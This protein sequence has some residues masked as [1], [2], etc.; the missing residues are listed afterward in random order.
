MNS[1]KGPRS[2]LADVLADIKNSRTEDEY[3]YNSHDLAPTP[4]KRRAAV[5]YVA[6]SGHTP[7][8]S[9]TSNSNSRLPIQGNQVESQKSSAS[10]PTSKNRTC[11]LKLFER[12]V[13]LAPFSPNDPDKSSLYPICRSWIHGHQPN[14]TTQAKDPIRLTNSDDKALELTGMPQ[15]DP[16]SEGIDEINSLPLPKT[17]PDVIREFNLAPDGQDIDIRIPKSVREFEAPEDLVQMIDKSIDSLSHHDC[18]ELNKLRWKKV[19]ND[20][21]EARRIHESRYED[22]FKILQDMFMTSQRNV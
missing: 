12:N 10:T 8:Q 5:N 20:W 14:A 4:A 18:L 22:S 17:K 19:R 16:V 2:K 3:D 13:D 9:R 15:Q 11:I 7:R 6:L 1:Q 21:R